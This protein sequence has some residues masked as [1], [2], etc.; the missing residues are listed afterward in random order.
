MTAIH[1]HTIAETGDLEIPGIPI[2][3]AAQHGKPT[4]WYLSSDVTRVIVTLAVTGEDGPFVEDNYLGTALL[5]DGYFVLH[6]F[7]NRKIDSER[8]D[9]DG[10]R[11]ALER[12]R[13][14]NNKGKT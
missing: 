7:T 11:R 6:A 1:K 12:D 10:V 14:T 13:L 3:F 8:D 9:I 2:H 4:I 5:D